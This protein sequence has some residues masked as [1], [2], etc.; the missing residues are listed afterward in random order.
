MITIIHGL[1]LGV[2]DHSAIGSI[3]D[4]VDDDGYNDDDDD[5]VLLSR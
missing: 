4:G 3:H 1:I 2:F 5:D